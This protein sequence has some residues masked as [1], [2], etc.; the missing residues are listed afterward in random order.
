[1]LYLILLLMFLI[2]FLVILGALLLMIFTARSEVPISGNGMK[3]RTTPRDHPSPRP[4][5]GKPPM[6]GKNASGSSKKPVTQVVV[7]RPPTL[8]ALPRP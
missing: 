4:P 1:M 6:S 8:V 2:Q 7:S 5:E 3:E